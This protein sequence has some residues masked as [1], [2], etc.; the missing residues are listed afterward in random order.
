MAGPPSGQ[1]GCGGAATRREQRARPDG[2]GRCRA[3]GRAGWPG[4]GRRS[5]GPTRPG[6]RP[7]DRS[8]ARR[9][10]SSQAAWKPATVQCGVTGWIVARAALVRTSSL[11]TDMMRM[12]SRRSVEPPFRADQVQQDVRGDGVLHAG[13]VGADA[14]L[15]GDVVVGCQF[16]RRFVAAVTAVGGAVVLEAGLSSAITHQAAIRRGGTG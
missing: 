7:R 10:R 14:V 4:S 8:R 11:A 5:G 9:I 12:P 3:A 6:S 2:R 15:E 16:G 13:H 1:A